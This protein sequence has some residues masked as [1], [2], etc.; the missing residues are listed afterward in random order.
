[1]QKLLSKIFSI[2]LIM[3]SVTAVANEDSIIPIEKLV[4][5]GQGTN[6]ALSP[7]GDYYAAMVSVDKNVCDIKDE[8]D[9]EAQRSKRV[10]VV[11]DLKTMKPKVISG[12]TAGSA[13]SDF[14][15]LND[16]TL[17][18][19]RDGRASLDSYSLYTINRDGTN[20]KLLIAAKAFERKAGFQYPSY[21]ASYPK[22]PNKIMITLNRN[23]SVSQFRDLYWLDINTKQTELVARVP[24][25]KNEAVS[26]WLL[27]WDGNAKGF[28]TFTM[29]GPDM[30]LVT[31]FYKYNQDGSYKKILSCRHQE[32]CFTP[33]GFD[34]DN[35]TILGVGQAVRSD[36]SILDETDTNALW[37]M[38]YESEEYVEMIYHDQ[39]FDLSSPLQGDSTLNLWFDEKG[40]GLFGFSYQADKPVDVYFDGYFQSVKK[41]LEGVFPGERV[42][43]SDWSQDLSKFLVNVRSDTNPG[44]SYM[45]DINKGSL[46]L[47]SDFAPWMKDYKLAKMEPFTYKAR[48]GLKLHGYITLPTSYK[49]GTKIPFIL[50]PHGGP[51]ARDYWGYNPEV[52]FYASRGYGVIQPNYRG[53]TGHGRNEMILA[54]HQMGKTMQTDKYDALMW[55]NEKGYVDM[56]NVCISGAS[57]GGYAAM[58]AATKNPN[59]FNCIITYVGTY[60]LTD[61]DRRGLMWSEAAMPMEY[62][63]KGNPDIPEDYENLYENSPIFHVK[64]VDDPVLII[65]GRRDAQVR[66]QETVDMVAELNRYGKDYEYII[67]GDEGHG[68]RSE[69]ARLNLYKDYEKFLAKHLK[70][71]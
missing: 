23:S 57:Y 68:F 62:I 7:S 39:D 69:V 4:C 20:T 1:M 28:S 24:S 30:G 11:T 15:W 38:D 36:G 25:I 35:K 12:T 29:E 65:T 48:D 41:S 45:F 67:K 47:I 33:V 18:V 54:N 50:H 51:N 26:N 8:T 22:F 27:D 42:S 66:F 64:N 16:E 17:L 9:Q 37:A 53:S 63:E 59:M 31:T 3:S 60:D 70:K 40:E 46:S 49:K 43:L 21:Y 10:L 5:Y 2:T 32:A 58:Q 6:Q 34:V 56:N 19:Y 55:A 14:A 44:A 52:Q 61:N 71:N 13:V